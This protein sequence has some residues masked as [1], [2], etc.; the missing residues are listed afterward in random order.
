MRSSYAFG[1]ITAVILIIVIAACSD[2]K[3]TP[4]TA[5]VQMESSKYGGTAVFAVRRDPPAAWDIMRSTSYDIRQIGMPIWGSG[6]LVRPCRD[7]ARKVCP[8]LAKSWEV[9]DDFTQWTFTIRDGVLWHDGTPFTA[10][11][12]KFWLTLVTKGWTVGDKVRA[13]ASWHRD[14]GDVQSID[15]INGNQV[16]LTLKAPSQFLLEAISSSHYMIQLPKH[17]VEPLLEQGKMTVAPADI[18][19]VGTGPFVMKSYQ[20][21]SGAELSRFDGY[22]EKD[23]QGNAMPYLDG[24]RFAIMNDP[25]AYDAAFRS[26]RVDGGPPANSHVLTKE[27]QANYVADLGDQVY[28]IEIP[29]P[30]AISGAIGFNLLKPGPWNDVRVRQAI[31]LYID[32]QAGIDSY[33]GGFGVVG[34]IFNPGNP[35]SVPDL[36]QWPGWN[37]NTKE[38]DR[39][40]AKQLMA[41]AGYAGGFSMKITCNNTG[42]WLSRCI[43]LQDQLKGLGIDLKL[44]VMD[45]ASAAEATQTLNYDAYQC[46][47]CGISVELPEATE[48]ILGPYSQTKVA[49]SKHEDPKISEFYA[50]LKKATTIQERT[51]IW[52]Q[53]EHYV[54]VENPMVIPLANPTFVMPYRTHIKGRPA[55]SVQVTNY[56]D[57]TTVWLDK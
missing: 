8:G 7:D 30:G 52:R 4:T 13:P 18:N 31:Q 47:G 41:A 53:L 20:K 15:I 10:E 27:R 9:N 3:P 39:A 19:Y 46:T 35:F 36:L 26:G 29:N 14:F 1:A 51:K 11:D 45:Q 2:D 6:N 50:A 32:K 44:D 12:V 57:M 17:L 5:P 28:Y 34:G 33:N 49:F 48:L 55:P 43:F 23:K 37:P 16:R 56:L 24:I 38:Q 25:S 21:G 42:T 40:R 54:L 22:W